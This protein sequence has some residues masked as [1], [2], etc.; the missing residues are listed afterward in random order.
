MACTVC[1]DAI[2]TGNNAVDESYDNFER[3]Y[4]KYMGKG[5]DKVEDRA[6]KRVFEY[7]KITAENHTRLLELAPGCG[8]EPISCSLQ[9]TSIDDPPRYSALSYTWGSYEYHKRVLVDGK[10]FLVS[11]ENGSILASHSKLKAE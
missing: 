7:L 8:D 11:S 5:K 2:R 9:E 6:E 4:Y 1:K 10:E 3:F